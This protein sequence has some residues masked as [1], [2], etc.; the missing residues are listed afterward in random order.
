[1]NKKNIKPETLTRRQARR[2]RR[3]YFTSAA[4]LVLC[5]ALTAPAFAASDP[6]T[7][8]DRKSVV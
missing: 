7:I 6:L 3:L 5:A 1:M 2:A 4:A 8:V